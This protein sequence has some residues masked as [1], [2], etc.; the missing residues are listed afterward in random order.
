MLARGRV[1]ALTCAQHSQ[2][3]AMA[4]VAHV[5]TEEKIETFSRV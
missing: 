2:L 5:L 1:L 4:N 3:W